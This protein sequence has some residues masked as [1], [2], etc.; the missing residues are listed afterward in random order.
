MSL[1][2]AGTDCTA[3]QHLRD[4]AANC[5]K[6]Q[7]RQLQKLCH[8]ICLFVQSSTVNNS[9]VNYELLLRGLFRVGRVPGPSMGWVGWAFFK[10]CVD[11]VGFKFA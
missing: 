5:S 7:D 6:A 1:V 4:V 2:T 11:W 8:L 9:D 3:S 10:F